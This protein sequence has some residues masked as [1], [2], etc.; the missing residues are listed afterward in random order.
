MTQQNNY[1]LQPEFY[2]VDIA[3]E[4]GFAASLENPTEN[5]ELDW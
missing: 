3:P 5:E 4:G 1:Y 2:I